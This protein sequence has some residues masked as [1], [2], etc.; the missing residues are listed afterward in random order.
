MIDELMRLK[1]VRMLEQDVNTFP[2]F[3]RDWC[4]RI[5]ARVDG[6]VL[7]T[8]LQE[9]Q[10]HLNPENLLEAYNVQAHTSNV[11]EVPCYFSHDN[12]LAP[13]TSAA[14]ESSEDFIPWQ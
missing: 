2:N 13:N 1:P 3:S 4:I 5:T 8:L 12:T 9:L 6:I 11:P 14:P 7:N 10:E